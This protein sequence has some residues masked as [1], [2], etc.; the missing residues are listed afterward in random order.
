MDAVPRAKQ[1]GELVQGL[2]GAMNPRSAKEK[3]PAIVARPIDSNF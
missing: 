3:G 1:D 2:W